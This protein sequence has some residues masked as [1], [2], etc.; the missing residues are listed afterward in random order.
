MTQPWFFATN[1]LTLADPEYSG[2]I[3]AM[4]ASQRINAPYLVPYMIYDGESDPFCDALHESGVQIIHHEFSMIEEIKKNPKWPDPVFQRIARGTYLRLDIPI[5]SEMLNL[6]T[7]EV[8]YTDIDVL[9]LK[10]P[11]PRGLTFEPFAVGPEFDP[12]DFINMNSG[13]MYINIP[14]MAE[15]RQAFMEYVKTHH[16]TAVTFDQDSL[17]RFYTGQWG[18]L[19]IEYNWKPYWGV[20]PDACIVHFH[21]PKPSMRATDFAETH[22]SD[23]KV[24]GYDYYCGVYDTYLG[25]F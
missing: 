6:N 10:Q 23:M 17:R 22:I 19:P 3:L 7:A 24:G 25:M 13:V 18:H 14:K 2:M 5:L 12:Q 21:G 16:L 20:N 9:F 15:T 11:Q 4:L 1:S 8:L